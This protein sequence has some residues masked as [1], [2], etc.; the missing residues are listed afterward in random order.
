[1]EQL[2]ATGIVT[3]VGRVNMDRNSVENLQEE[4]AV[5]SLAGTIEW[6]EN[7]KKRFVNTYPILTPRFIPSCSDELMHGLGALASEERLRVQ[8]HLSENCAEIAWV[9]ELVPLATSYANAYEMFGA[10][11]DASRPAIMA[12]CVYSGEEE[13]AIMKKYGTYVSHCP[14]SNMNLSS[15]IAPARRFLEAGLHVGLGT[16]VAAGSSLNLLKTMLCTLQA[17]KL[18]YRLKDEAAKPLSFEEVFYLATVGAAAI[19]VRLEPLKTTMNLMRLL[20]MTA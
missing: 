17:S 15:G 20:S 5:A 6:L 1:M 16:D 14:E 7:V 9:K 12:H 4:S 13:I 3:Y 2:E 18:Y 11:G 10:L 19:L 8:S